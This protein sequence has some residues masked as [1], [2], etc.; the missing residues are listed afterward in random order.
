MDDA[1]I[2]ECENNRQ[3]VPKQLQK[4]L[5]QRYNVDLGLTQIR[6]RLIQ[7]GLHGAVCV[8]KPLL[9]PKNKLKR[10][11]WALRHKD[12]TVE[13]WKTVMWT[14][15]K[16]FEL[17]N[18]KRRT[19]CRRRKGEPLREDTVQGT[20]KHGG[21]SIMVWGSIGNNAP[22]K[23]AKIDGIMEQ[24]KYLSI[25]SNEAIPSGNASFQGGQWIFQQ[26]NDPKHNSKLCKTYLSSQRLP[27]NFSV[28]DWPP[29]SPDI[30]PIELLW[31][32]VDRQVQSTRPSNVSQLESTVFSVWA[33][34][35]EDII[36]KLIKRLPRICKAVNQA[37]GG[38][39]DE[40][41]H[42]CTKQLVYH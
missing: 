27:N 25:L 17:F 35:S 20:V 30:S 13:K 21:G 34:I 37:N 32:E 11:V 42:A 16:K 1:I 28:M 19:I 24:T 4:L 10:L 9:K 6:Q 39:F 29:Q 23:I 22:G 36:D 15:E 26:D 18:G 41:L 33:N 7:A 5:K 31:D 2:S 40:H 3:L 38:Y 12:W 14:D 8:K